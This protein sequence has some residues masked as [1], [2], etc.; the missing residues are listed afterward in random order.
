MMEEQDL[1]IAI[2]PLMKQIDR[3]DP[4]AQMQIIE[5][6]AAAYIMKASQSGMPTDIVMGAM[7]KHIKQLHG[8]LANEIKDHGKITVS[9]L[10]TVTKN[11][12]AT[13]W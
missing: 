3:H 9:D 8:K 5:V 4:V 12:T 10:Q 7:F 1:I 13:G 6:L 2:E 11:R